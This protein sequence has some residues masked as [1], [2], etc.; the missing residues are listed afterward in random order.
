MGPFYTENSISMGRTRWYWLAA[1]V[2]LAVAAS[3]VV[4]LAGRSRNTVMR[5]EFV[6]AQRL[7]LQHVQQRLDA[8]FADAVQLTTAGAIT[9]ASLKHDP[10]LEWLVMDSLFAAR[11]D[12]AVYGLG[13]FFAPY[14][15]DRRL[16]YTSF[17]VHGGTKRLSPYDHFTGGVDEVR[18]ATNHPYQTA[19]NYRRYVWWSAALS[20]PDRINYAGPYVEDHRSFIS[21]VRAFTR[22]GKVVGVMAVDTLTSTFKQMLTGGLREGDVVW[23]QSTK[24]GADV[25]ISSQSV[26]PPQDRIIARAPLAYSTT[27]LVLSSDAAP[28]IARERRTLLGAT[29][30]IGTIWIFA[31]FIGVGLVQ[32]WRDEAT[33]KRLER[34]QTRLEGEVAVARRVEAAL[35]RTAYTDA[36][37][38]LQNRAAVMERLGELLATPAAAPH[39]FFFVDLDRFN[40]INETLGHPAGDELIVSV[41]RRLEAFAGPGT[42]V[43][44]LGGD[45]FAVVAP[46]LRDE[47][48]SI[49]DAIREVIGQP[50]LLYG[51]TLYPEA[52]IG[53]VALDS[54]YDRAEDVLRDA[55]IAVY[56]AKHQGRARAAIFDNEMRRRIEIE[57]ELETELRRALD[58]DEIVP[59][60]QPIYELRGG[61]L[62][63]FEALA[64]WQRNDGEIAGGF[65]P[66]AE[67][68]GLARRIDVAILRQVFRHLGTIVALFPGCTVSANISVAELAT[69]GF[70]TTLEELLREYAVDV[71]LLNLE[72]TETAMMTGGEQAFASLDALRALGLRLVLDDFGTG[73]SSLGYLQRLPIAGLKI[74]RAFV[75]HLPHDLR[76][77]EIVRSIVTLAESFGLST[78]AE[79]IETAEQVA[80]LGRLGVRYG[81]G[82]FFSAARE[83]S[84]LRE[85]ILPDAG[86]TSSK[87][88]S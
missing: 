33:T 62:R 61:A 88:V 63:G 58:R 8:Y 87:T 80:I 24:P 16:R 18:F 51:Q 38:G 83:I 69:P 72:I 34:E 77:V 15:Y 31:L 59:Y 48:P 13:A 19:D 27:E 9:S 30:M 6:A 66:F 12:P 49:A 28:L 32:R 10:K 7:R 35:R 23:V 82:F 78:T 46:A 20:T 11:H 50:A 65:V 25:L 5:S 76:T 64:R 47:I 56:E 42:Y 29:V 52:S 40:I 22:N 71:D 79:G 21:V 85:L 81:Q 45:E 68:R 55:D 39:A 44:R 41:A 1:I 54:N 60:Y 74:D 53:A 43:A 57:S 70:A 17:Y 84:A 67:T 4:V 36:L 37:T 86:S 73:Y 3:V 2:V 14:A 75:E 26:P